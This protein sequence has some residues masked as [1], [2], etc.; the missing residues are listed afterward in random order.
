MKQI[1]DTHRHDVQYDVGDWV[2]VKLCP[3]R[4]TSVTNTTYSKLHKRFYGPFQILERIG[5]VAYKLQLPSESK[6]HPVFHCSMLK[7]FHKAAATPVPVATLPPDTVENQPV[8]IPMVILN[9]RWT[10]TTEPCL[11]V[12]VQWQGLL[13]DDTSWED[14]VTLKRLTTLRTRCFLMS[15]GMIAYWPKKG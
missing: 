12:L 11:E 14:W 15:W 10:Q 13:A 5:V 3:H 2:L 9:T 8:I 7:P 6:I 1:A 4:Q